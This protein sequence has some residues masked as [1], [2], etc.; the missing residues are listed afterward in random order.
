MEQ[1]ISHESRHVGVAYHRAKIDHSRENGVGHD[2][3]CIAQ[4]RKVTTVWPEVEVANH[5]KRHVHDHHD[6][7][8]DD[9]HA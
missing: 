7:R 3:H 6:D 4:C 1:E 2:Q 5:G 8:H 9:R